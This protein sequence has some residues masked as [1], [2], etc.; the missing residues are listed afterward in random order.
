MDSE[1]VSGSDPVQDKLAELK[2]L[3]EKQTGEVTLLKDTLLKVNVLMQKIETNTAHEQVVKNIEAFHKAVVKG[4]ET[5]DGEENNEG[6]DDE[7]D[8]NL[9]FHWY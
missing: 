9:L 6:S 1:E 5:K 2:Q 8:G 3:I 7:W 4:A